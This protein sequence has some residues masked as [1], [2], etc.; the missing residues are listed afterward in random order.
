MKLLWGAINFFVS[1]T[2]TGSST[3]LPISRSRERSRGE[4]NC[5]PWHLPW[6][7]VIS[8]QIIPL[9]CLFT[10]LRL[11]NAQKICHVITLKKRAK[12]RTEEERQNDR[13]KLYFIS[14]IINPL[15]DGL[16]YNMSG[17]FAHCSYF[18]S[19]SQGSEKYHTT[20]KI[21]ARI[22]IMLNHRIRCIYLPLDFSS[23]VVY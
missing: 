9:L 3:Q 7:Q 15:F 10:I 11:K 18:S 23:T 5:Y 2:M 6:T 16:T 4:I 21:S 12:I 22:I 8:S 13:T 14:W 17:H 19:P 1:V 20:R